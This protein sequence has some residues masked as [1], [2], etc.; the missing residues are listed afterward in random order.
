MRAKIQAKLDDG[1][2]GIEHAL[3]LLDDGG[4]TDTPYRHLVTEAIADLFILKRP[5]L[6]LHT[7]FVKRLSHRAEPSL[8][9]FSLN[10]DPLIERAAEVARV[11]VSDGFLGVEHA[12]F[13]P[14]VFEERI[15]PNSWQPQGTP[16]RRN[17]NADTPA[18][19]PW[20]PRLV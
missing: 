3:D 12:Y 19:T 8:K 13:A 6:D 14:Q 5:S 4:A 10:Y 18:E 16:V 20:L 1:A 2:R 11:R 17:G 15:G 7:K 9:V